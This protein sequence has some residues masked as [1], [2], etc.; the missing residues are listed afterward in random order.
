M[1]LMGKDINLASHEWVQRVGLTTDQFQSVMTYGPGEEVPT[2]GEY[3]N[4]E[5][6]ET[7]Q[8]EAGDAFPQG[9]HALSNE[10]PAPRYKSGTDSE[11][12]TG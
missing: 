12:V 3:R 6:G 5:T 7:E 4:L 11:E 1:P 2:S 9:R 10:I 8:L